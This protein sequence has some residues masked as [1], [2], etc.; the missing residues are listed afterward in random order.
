MSDIIVLVD[1]V[2]ITAVVQRGTADAVVQA[3]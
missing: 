2:L 3:A 1:V